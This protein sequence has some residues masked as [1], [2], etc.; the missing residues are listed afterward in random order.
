MT[1][2]LR[3]GVVGGGIGEEYVSAFA[4]NP[5]A[6]VVA[7]CT[8]TPESAE[9]LAR[10]YGIGGRYT[11]HAAMLEREAL[12]VVVVAV[13]NYLHHPITLAAIE[14]GAHVVCEKPLALS[15]HE[16]VAMTLR[17]EELRRR[18]FVPFTWRFLP[19][20]R[21]MKELLSSGFVGRPYHVDV[22]YFVCGWGDPHGPMR[23]QY[24]AASAGSGSLG[25]VGSHAVHLVQWW[26]GDFRKVCT[27][28][29]TLVPERAT[30]N[31]ATEAVSV[32]DTCALIAE[33][34]DGTPVVFHTSS[35]AHGPRVD[36]EIR[37]HGSDG[38]LVFEDD[39]SSDDA[40]LGRVR[41]TREGD[42]GWTRLQVS[43]DRLAEELVAPS[44]PLRA[45]FERMAAEVVAAVRDDRPAV[46]SFHDGVRVQRVLDA[47]LRSAAAASWEAV[48]E[49]PASVAT[50]GAGR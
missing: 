33:L 50:A 8:R 16:A 30:P 14:A 10:R 46:P 44:A 42:G 11:D 2:R 40:S 35:V 13:P 21:R 29:K 39:W 12:D 45:C 38:A 5:D 43:S 32:D 1:E 4:R 25:N 7:V 22:R 3:V 18:H 49:Q 6:E 36:V 41:A 9:R 23:W 19:A 31:G 27:L 15:V 34:H 17:A 26:L 28:L 48:E 20:A 24:D 37:V 47:A